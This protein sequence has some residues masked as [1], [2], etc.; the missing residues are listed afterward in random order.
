MNIKEGITGS[1]SYFELHIPISVFKT[2]WS[3][4]LKVKGQIDKANTGD[5]QTKTS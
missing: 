2:F 3:A 5:K 1:K 4:W